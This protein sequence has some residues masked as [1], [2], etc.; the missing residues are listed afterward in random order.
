MMRSARIIE[1]RFHEDGFVVIRRPFSS[2]ESRYIQE[3][4]H[5]FVRTQAHLLKPGEVYFE[6]GPSKAVKSIHHLDSYSDYFRRIMADDRLLERVQ[7]LFPDAQIIPEAVMFFAK[8][9]GAGSVTHSHQD[10]A[11]QHWLPPDALTVTLA[12]DE[13][14]PTNGPLICRKGSHKL[15]VL[16]HCSSGVMGLSRTLIDSVDVEAYPEVALCMKPGDVAFHHVNTVHRSEANRSSRHRRQ[17]GIGYRS[18]KAS[19]DSK[20]YER[21]IKEPEQ[22]HAKA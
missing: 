18:S 4:L 7:G 12:I 1:K 15:G 3:K 11:F 13:S 2:E 22:L 10:N 20:A 6:E 8:M 16:P 17:L 9:A 14:D 19:R 21:Y 5:D